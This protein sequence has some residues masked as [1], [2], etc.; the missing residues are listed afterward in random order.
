MIKIVDVIGIVFA[1]VSAIYVDQRLKE[2]EMLL[3]IEINLEL[4]I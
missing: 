4:N 2:L 3:N 1:G